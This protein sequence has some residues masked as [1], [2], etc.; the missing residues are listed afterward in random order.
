MRPFVRNAR[1]NPTTSLNR[2]WLR[3]ILYKNESSPCRWG[4]RCCRWF[5]HCTSG[6]RMAREGYIPAERGH[7]GRG[8]RLA[9]REGDYWLRIARGHPFRP[10]RPPPQRT[11]PP[12]T[13]RPSKDARG[14]HASDA[15][16]STPS[17]VGLARSQFHRRM[18]ASR[19]GLV[20]HQTDSTLVVVDPCGGLSPHVVTPSNGVDTA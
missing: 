16:G 14:A 10:R 4:S 3:P 2:G 12:G 13:V 18:R 19:L 11:A 6:C 20:V 5:E 15:P 1:S 7:S 8:P 9:I 17:G